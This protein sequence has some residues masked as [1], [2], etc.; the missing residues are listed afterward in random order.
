MKNL[1]VL[2]GNVILRRTNNYLQ[3]VLF[4]LIEQIWTNNAWRNFNYLVAC[5]KTGDALAIDPLDY[6]QCLKVAGNRGWNITKILNTH[7]HHD[8]IAGN[9][10]LQQH[11][12][13]KILAH[14]DA[15]GVIS[16]VDTALKGGEVIGVGN[17]VKLQVLDTPGHTM[18]HICL[19]SKTPIPK[20]FSGDTLF[21]AGVGNCHS[22]G[23]PE[24][25]FATFSDVFSNL[26]DETEIYPGHD[27]IVN[28][29]EFT[30][31]REPS[32]SMAK[33]MLQKVK[34]QDTNNPLVTT[35]G[36]EKQINCFLRLDSQEIIA[37]LKRSLTNFPKQ[38]TAKDIFLSLRAMRND[39]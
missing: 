11:T 25:L 26:P 33:K 32:N 17:S 29:L 34:F 10:P 1:Q 7:E 38:P 22:G 31:D 5:P 30:L 8:H 19:L 27:Y 16:D 18:S 13:A 6:R 12:E 2:I 9:K 14:C 20:L 3:K 28:N 15:L 39:W 23:H 36:L 4:M 21:N 35:I 37:G 24:A